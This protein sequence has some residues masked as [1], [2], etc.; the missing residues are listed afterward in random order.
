MTNKYPFKICLAM[1][2]PVFY[3]NCY[4]NRL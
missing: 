2:Q 1:W 3:S 4:W